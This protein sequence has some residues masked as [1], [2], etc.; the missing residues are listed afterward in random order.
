[1]ENLIVNNNLIVSDINR[2]NNIQTYFS[3][4]GINPT[5]IDH[6]VC[7][8]AIDNRLDH[9]EPLRTKVNHLDFCRF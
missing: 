5:L 2:L 1:M 8:R 7:S 6:F 4:D 9:N 3:D